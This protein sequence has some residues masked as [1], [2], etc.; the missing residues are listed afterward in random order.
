M[1]WML[2][3]GF[4]MN[5]KQAVWDLEY[6]PA[7]EAYVAEHG[8]LRTIPRSH[9]TLG[10]LVHDIRTNHA[11]VPPEHMEWM[12]ANGFVMNH[13]QAVWDLDYRLAFEQYLAKH[14]TLRTITNSH[15][16]VGKLVENIRSCNTSVPPEHMNWL[17][18][19]GF[20][21][22]CRNIAA[23]GAGYLGVA[24][25]DLPADATLNEAVMHCL[26]EAARLELFG[27]LSVPELA[28]RYNEHRAR[29]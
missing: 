4:V 28:A 16:T 5:L 9:P 7:Y 24:R 12:L 13:Y 18:A 27:R 23:H 26:R 20:R 14:G 17:R 15:P 19:N 10:R 3:N 2:A 22:A 21:W 11:S 1:E 8:T 6:R 29:L 25:A